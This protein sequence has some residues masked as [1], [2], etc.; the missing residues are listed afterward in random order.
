[1]HLRRTPVYVR[2]A[3]VL[4]RRAAMH[5]AIAV[6]IG[7]ATT[8]FLHSLLLGWFVGVALFASMTVPFALLR[9]ADLRRKRNVA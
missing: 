3:A 2:R 9:R 5:I 7:W 4:V 8:H 1:M 6:I